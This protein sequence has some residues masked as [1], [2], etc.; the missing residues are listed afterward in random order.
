MKKQSKKEPKIITNADE[1]E[2]EQLSEVE[3]II[4][5]FMAMQMQKGLI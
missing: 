4:G 1:F 2:K 5:T 3:K